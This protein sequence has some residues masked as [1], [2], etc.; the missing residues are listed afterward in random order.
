M[1]EGEGG[2]ARINP[3]IQSL[4]KF[5]GP[6]PYRIPSCSIGSWGKFEGFLKKSCQILKLLKLNLI[7]VI[8]RPFFRFI[9]IKI[10]EG[11]YKLPVKVR[12]QLR[13]PL[14]YINKYL[15]APFVQ[16]HLRAQEIS[17]FQIVPFKQ[18]L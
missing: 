4:Q 3:V 8:F 16:D 10:R 13:P 9:R 17:G 12:P 18:R 14:V 2:N 5:K 11:F 6:F 15:Y 1:A 7:R